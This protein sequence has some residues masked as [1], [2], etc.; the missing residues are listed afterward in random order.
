M[1]N[2]NLSAFSTRQDIFMYIPAK[3]K[4]YKNSWRI[5]YSCLDPESKNLS[6]QQIRV[7][8]IRKRFATKRE[9]RMYFGV[10]CQNINAKLAG[11]WNP[12]LHSE[13]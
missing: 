2:L 10:V 8:A 7:D 3:L 6:R 9:A 12:F 13:D 1:S 5:E 11:G 4:E